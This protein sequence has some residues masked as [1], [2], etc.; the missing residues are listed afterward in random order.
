M[1]LTTQDA[2][3]EDSGQAGAQFSIPQTQMIEISLG[4]LHLPGDGG[5]DAIDYHGDRVFIVVP[6]G[7]F[8]KRWNRPDK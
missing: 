4:N 8:D 7:L 6:Q 5:G 2:M 1:S 3:V